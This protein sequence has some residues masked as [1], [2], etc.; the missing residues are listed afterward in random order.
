MTHRKPALACLM[1]LA[2]ASAF[3]AEA[4][5]TLTRKKVKT[6]MTAVYAGMTITELGSGVV[7]FTDRPQASESIALEPGKEPESVAAELSRKGAQVVVLKVLRDLTP[8]LWLCAD[9]CQRSIPF[10]EKSLHLSLTHYD[11]A[12]I[13][14]TIKGA[15]KK[16]GLAAD[17]EFAL[18]LHNVAEARAYQSPN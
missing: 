16:D 7:V 9:G 8:M 15:S 2:C 17:L 1:L 18:H 3:A 5:G 13:E 11:D 10:D 14:G 12:G 4:E 6:P